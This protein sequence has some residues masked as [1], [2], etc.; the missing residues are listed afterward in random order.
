MSVHESEARVTTI[1]RTMRTAPPVHIVMREASVRDRVRPRLHDGLV[2]D[3]LA[4]IPPPTSILHYPGRAGGCDSA[5]MVANIAAL[6][7]GFAFSV[8]R[9]I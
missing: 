6:V 4:R 8:A 9:N 1:M 3:L 2:S 7:T 5:T